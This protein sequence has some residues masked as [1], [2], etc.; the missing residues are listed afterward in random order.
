MSKVRFTETKLS[1]TGKKGILTPDADGYYELVIGGLNTFNSAGEYYTLEG[2]KQ[3][4]EESSIFMRR[5]RN[6]ALLAEL[7]HPSKL[8]GMSMDEYINRILKID[9]GNVCCHIKEVWLDET[10][11]K[12]Y[13]KLNNPNLVAIVAKIKPYGPK[14]Q[15]LKESLENPNQNTFFSIR[16]LTNDFYQ[17]GQTIRVLQQIVTFDGC[18]SESGIA[19]A[20]KWDTPSLESNDV[21]VTKAQIEKVL[22]Q[23][24][25]FV[26]TEDSK[27]LMKEC[28]KVFEPKQ[29][30]KPIYHSW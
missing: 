14:G 3:L 25:S 27:I 15:H 6:G 4:F 19:I 18:V 23:N 5:V 29:T 9:E 26:A 22:Y 11:G 16:A 20:N 2:A 8:P 12:R 7:G 24:N 10:Y 28:L 1:A 30:P 17:R 13:P 21:T